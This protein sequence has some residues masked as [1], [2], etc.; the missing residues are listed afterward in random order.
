MLVVIFQLANSQWVWKTTLLENNKRMS[1][2]IIV[3]DFVYMNGTI[4]YTET[5]FLIEAEKTQF[6]FRSN[7]IN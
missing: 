4:M 6:E 5:R 7:E 1:H 2:N 3:D